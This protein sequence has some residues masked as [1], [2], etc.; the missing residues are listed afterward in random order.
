MAARLL[1]DFGAHLDR[2]N[3]DRET[4][5]QVDGRRCACSSRMI[6]R[7]RD[8]TQVAVPLRQSGKL[9]ER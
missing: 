4:A 8:C 3:N 7:A 2:V 1:F 9:E 5:A 6:T